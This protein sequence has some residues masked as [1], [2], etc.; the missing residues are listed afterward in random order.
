[1]AGHRAPHPG[2]RARL[3]PF[4]PVPCPGAPARVGS[5][6]RARAEGG[7][8][9]A[10]GAHLDGSRPRPLPPP[11][12]RGVR[13]RCPRR[14]SAQSPR[15]PSPR[16]PGPAMGSVPSAVKHCLSPQQLL[17][18][19]LWIGD[20]AAGAADPA[21]VL[22][23]GPGRPPCAHCPP[24]SARFRQPRTPGPVL[25]QP[26]RGRPRP[27]KAFPSPLPGTCR[28]APTGQTQHSP[29]RGCLQVAGRK[30]SPLCFPFGRDALCN[31]ICVGGRA[32]KIVPFFSVPSLYRVT[33]TTD[34]SEWETGKAPKPTGKARK[35]G[36]M[37]LS[38]LS[39]IIPNVFMLQRT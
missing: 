6:D 16:S 8:R 25:R 33:K 37:K 38:V 13:R 12:P 34:L 22:P 31:V 15:L 24:A 26:R 39:L 7:V 1:M 23:R 10:A 2:P 30:L 35:P 20:A 3:L 27:L 9:S 28:P 5:R 14:R 11:G 29:H 17:R 21:Q 32:S 36:Q 18:E 19:H 4:G